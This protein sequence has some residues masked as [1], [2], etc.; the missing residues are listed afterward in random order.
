MASLTQT[1]ITARKI[2]RYGAYAIIL[3][4]V[5][6][7]MLRGAIALYKR[8]FP[9]PPPKPT[10]AFGKLPALPFPEKNTGRSFNYTLELPE[11]KLPTLPK[12]EI[13]YFMPPFSSNIAVVDDAKALADR[14]GFNPDGKPIVEKVPNVYIFQRE[15]GLSTL[16]MNI[17]TRIFSISYN[18]N[19]NPQ[20]LLGTPPDPERAISQIT[21]FLSGGGLLS[22]ELKGGRTTTEFLKMTGGIFSPVSSLSEADSIKVNIFRKNYGTNDSIP[23]VTPDMPEA[24]IW[25]VIG[26]AGRQIIAGEFNYFPLEAGRNGTYPLKTSETAFEQLKQGKAFIANAPDTE[27]I[28]IRRVYLGYYDAGQ[29]AK[30]YQPVVVFEGDGNFYAYVPAVAD[31]FYGNDNEN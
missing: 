20:V 27:N 14:L 5:G 30:Y 13:V 16:T 11:G 7:L 31:D 3:I 28:T 4:L 10:V 26:G 9:T 29:Y 22:D 19:A 18:I 25:F 17:I 6:R 24:N 12:Q 1:S 8:I 21:G 2:I 15:N 23:S